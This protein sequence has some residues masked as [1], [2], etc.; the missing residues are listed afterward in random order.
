M[1]DLDRGSEGQP[2]RDV[3]A[4][5]HAL[6]FRTEPDEHGYFGI[7]TESAIRE[8]QQRRHL[9]VDGV[10][11][12]NT[13]Q[14]LVEA[15]HVLGDRVV[16]LRYPMVR[17]DDVRTLQA[18][19]N[20]FGFDAGREDG[21]F[22]PR[23][24][25]ALR[26]FQR[27][28]GLPDDGIAGDTTVQAFARLRPETHEQLAPAF[29]EREALRQ[30]S[31]VQMLG[32]VIAIDPGHGVD[33][34]GAAGPTGLLE[35]TVAFQ[36]AEVLADELRAR[37]AAPLLLRHAEENPTPSAR[38]RVANEAGA[39][40]LIGMHL[41]SQAEPE[42]EG[43]TVFY[44]G[45]ED[46]SSPA[47]HRLAELIQREL[48]ALGLV[49]G[50]THPK[51]LPI[52]RETRMPAVRVEPCFITNPHEEAALRDPGFRGRIVVAIASAVEAF[53]AGSEPE[54]DEGGGSGAA[55]PLEA[56]ADSVRS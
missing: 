10:V 9:I 14:D 34:P 20:A 28:V 15:G 4:R 31:P 1:R 8:F 56:Q 7:G 45:R 41:N 21:I 16:Y 30:L 39:R 22:G 52:L 43:T 32:A 50:R 12:P 46:W 36:L 23:T 49:D 53:F 40:L 54:L 18:R 5:L 2:V 19:L 55:D 3:Q 13:W 42:A 35:A 51:W 17:G 11:G 27:N 24:D 25:R 47:G 6:G 38:A 33:D 26:E 48:T 29:R 37:G 44:C